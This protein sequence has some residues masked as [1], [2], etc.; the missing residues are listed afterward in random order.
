V[1]EVVTN[2]FVR[3]FYNLGFTICVSI[4]VSCFVAIIRIDKLPFLFG[5]ILLGFLNLII[6]IWEWYDTYRYYQKYTVETGGF[7]LINILYLLNLIALS[8]FLFLI[9]SHGL[10]LWSYVG[11]FCLLDVL[12]IIFCVLFIKG[13]GD[14][15]DYKTKADFIS[16]VFG[17]DVPGLLINSF[18]FFLTYIGIVEKFS[19]YI[20]GLLYS[21]FIIEVLIGY[22]IMDS[23][24]RTAN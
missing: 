4:H 7:V 1:A 9:A 13:I 22:F 2:G 20:P 15:G 5:F 21:S 8:L 11:M 16:F 3:W 12:D 10:P 23:E 19:F 24:I 6:T 14:G 17:K 18:V